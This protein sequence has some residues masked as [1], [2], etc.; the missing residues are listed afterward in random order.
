[1]DSKS[2]PLTLTRP[3]RFALPH[4]MEERGLN[5]YLPAASDGWN[6]ARGRAG[7][8]WPGRPARAVHSSA[9]AAKPASPGGNPAA[10][11]SLKR[12]FL[13][14]FS[15]FPIRL[16]RVGGRGRCFGFLVITDDGFQGTKGDDRTVFA[17]G[18]E[19]DWTQGHGI[20]PTG[21]VGVIGRPG[22]VAWGFR[23]LERSPE[24]AKLSPMRSMRGIRVIKLPARRIAYSSAR[25]AVSATLR[26]KRGPAA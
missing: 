6:I 20:A 16:Y 10:G 23:V 21:I 3:P 22:K 1:M 2:Y 19:G 5:D 4:E 24:S 13:P 15:S 26:G 9:G 12:V 7:S 18:H 14:L 8:P 25:R 11:T 17:T